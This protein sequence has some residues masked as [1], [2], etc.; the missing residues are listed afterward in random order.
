LPQHIRS[1]ENCGKV[2]Y[3]YRRPGFE[4]RLPASSFG[5]HF[6]SKYREAERR[7]VHADKARAPQHQPMALAA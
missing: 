4:V 3:F 2:Y 6:K 1:F 7:K 5:P